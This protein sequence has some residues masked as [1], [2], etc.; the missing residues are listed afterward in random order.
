M[1]LELD[2]DTPADASRIGGKGLGL[3]RLFAAGL[4]VPDAWCIPAEVSL[5]RSAREACVDEELA[6][7]WTYVDHRYPGVPWAVRSSAVAE[8][9]PDASF[10]GVYET[11]LGIDSLDALRKAV[12]ACWDSLDQ[13][14]AGTYRK[15]VGI[16]AGD[17]IALILQ[18]MLQPEVAGVMLTANPLRPF[19]SETSI[20]AAWG[21]GESLVSGRTQPDHFLL[22]R[23][24]GDVL[25]RQLGAKQ[26]E[27]VWD[28][29][30]REQE[31]EVERREMFSLSNDNLAS[32]HLLAATV[33]EKIGAR[34]DLEWAIAGGRLLLLQDRPITNLPSENP[35]DVWSRRFGDEFLADCTMPLPAD[36]MLRWIIDM[37][38]KDMA[39]IQGRTD[40]AGMEPVRLHRGY[41]YFSAAF[42]IEGLRMLPASMRSTSAREWFPQLV[43]DRVVDAQ[44]TPRFMLGFLASPLRDREHSGLKGNLK[45]LEKHCANIE[46]TILPKLGQDYSTLDAAQWKS[47]FDEVTAMGEEHFRVVRWGL[48]VY[49][50]FLHATL[51]RLLQSWCGDE[52][53]ELYEAVISG[54]DDT[55]TADINRE[56]SELSTSARE[57]GTLVELVN[58]GGDYESLRAAT[59]ES[60][61]WSDYEAF[62]DRHGHR[63]DS[64]DIARPRWREQ[65]HLILEFVRAQLR[66]AAVTGSEDRGTSARQRRAAAEKKVLERAG[67]F[68]VGVLRK[69]VLTRMM[70]LVQQYTR[71]R[72]NQRYHLDYLLTHMRSL[73]L[74]QARRMVDRGILTAVDDVFLLRGPEFFALVDGG[75]PAVGLATEL[76]E[77]RAE[78]ARNSRRLP[79]TFL[80]D[81][82]ETELEGLEDP[83]AVDLPPGA[84]KG[85]GVCRG[86][87]RGPARVVKELSDLGSV[88]AGDV[89]VALNIDPGWTSVFPLLSGLVIETGGALSHGAILAREYG[90][91]AVSGV[92]GGLTAIINRATIEVDGNAGL[93]RVEL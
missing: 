32:L 29:E 83:E 78:F 84:L 9:L 90:I 81:G 56:I 19:A 51:E 67:G 93:V 73:V 25:E 23:E 47:Q 85:S 34:R 77:R 46:M 5:D 45:A 75:R 43:E 10:A 69:G 20:D 50:A 53:G 6:T 40:M 11:V 76:V 58:A 68:P 2:S 82:I 54:L 55:R 52:T 74:E 62:L 12:R 7:W 80:Y 26:V 27:T 61:F 42:Y 18:R 70:S 49:N 38:M 22:D 66:T 39:K 36:L 79:A 24:S 21:L 89:L 57:Y 8:D 16:G 30:I 3:V 37:S 59:P 63:S 44:W 87:A 28:H 33:T 91:P 35:T 41:A 65:P 4:P 15:S 64:R 14:R 13:Q 31:V 17:G 71:Y 48:T 88:E 1:I 72:E 92:S 60:E 86:V